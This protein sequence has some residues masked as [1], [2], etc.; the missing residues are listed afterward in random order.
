LAGTPAAALAAAGSYG[1]DDGD[2]AEGGASL[3]EPHLVQLLADGYSLWPDAQRL[4]DGS[5]SGSGSGGASEF[6]AAAALCRHN[7]GVARAAGAG[8]LALAWAVLAALLA[9][10]GSLLAGDAGFDGGTEEE[11]EDSA[12]AEAESDGGN[13]AEEEEEEDEEEEEEE[14][15][16][17]EEEKEEGGGK[18]E[19]EGA[20]ES[21]SGEGKKVRDARTP[22]LRTKRSGASSGSGGEGGTKAA[23]AAAREGAN[24]GAAPTAGVDV[25]APAGKR[26]TRRG[27]GS[28]REIAKPSPPVAAS[29]SAVQPPA[30]TAEPELLALPWLFEETVRKTRKKSV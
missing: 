3:R 21:D 27:R 24:A 14:E 20:G 7:G 22:P 6:G 11:D 25:A 4:A 10:A 28:T 18:D 2:E 9:P 15:E 8:H 26:A 1:D 13:Y 29:M 5:G 19:D 16:K 30:P 17:E 23:V 12:D